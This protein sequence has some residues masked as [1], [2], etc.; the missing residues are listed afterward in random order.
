MTSPFKEKLTIR[1]CVSSLHLDLPGPHNTW[2]TSQLVPGRYTK[3]HPD[4]QQTAAF[5]LHQ[6]DPLHMILAK[7]ELGKCHPHAVR[8]YAYLWQ[9]GVLWHSDSSFFSPSILVLALYLSSL[10]WF[11]LVPSSFLL[12]LLF[13]LPFLSHTLPEAHPALILFSFHPALFL[14]SFPL[15]FILPFLSPSMISPVDAVL[16]F[17]LFYFRSCLT[18]FLVLFLPWFACSFFLHFFC[19]PSIC[20]SF[21]PCAIS[22]VPSSFLLLLL[23]FFRSS[24][25]LFLLFLL[26]WFA[27][28]F[29]FHFSRLP[30]LCYSSFSFLSPTFSP[31]PRFFLPSFSCLFPFVRYLYLLSFFPYFFPSYF[32]PF[33]IFCLASIFLSFPKPTFP[34][35]V[36]PTFSFFPI[37]FRSFPAHNLV[38]VLF[39][40]PSTPSLPSYLSSSPY[41]C[42]SFSD[43]FHSSFS[44]SSK[45]HPAFIY[46]S[47]LYTYIQ[48]PRFFLSYF[49]FLSTV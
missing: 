47:F 44:P 24:L 45:S 1:C 46:V 10:L 17:L 6:G 22:L 19:F 48:L 29:T 40:F 20:Y 12:F 26:L 49:C 14:S 23:F 31:P 27:C 9:K 15:F 43:L 34:S 7:R 18:L 41:L 2:G 30:S 25:T 8:R 16:L 11:S 33:L 13:L 32:V 35:S 21:F 36:F 28:S 3:Q 5:L 38:L 42:C 39:A 37:S 4:L